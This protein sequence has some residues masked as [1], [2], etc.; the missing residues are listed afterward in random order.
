MQQIA[1]AQVDAIA[2]TALV[3]EGP[4]LLQGGGREVDPGDL[5]ALL[6]QPNGVKGVATAAIQDG[7]ARPGPQQLHHPD[8]RL[9]IEAL[10]IG[11]EVVALPLLVDL[12]LLEKLPRLLGLAVLAPGRRHAAVHGNECTPGRPS[13]KYANEGEKDGPLP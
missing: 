10:Q 13:R 9:V 11:V 5:Q 2:Q 7:R 8:H 1:L 6:R 4:G 3:H 12:L